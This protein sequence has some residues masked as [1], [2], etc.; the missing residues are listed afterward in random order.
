MSR[1]VAIYA[2]NALPSMSGVLGPVT[3]QIW[4]GDALSRNAAAG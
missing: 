3:R 2:L 4:F 1:T